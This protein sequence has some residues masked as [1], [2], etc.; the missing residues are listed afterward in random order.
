MKILVTGGSGRAGQ[1]IIPELLEH[2]HEVVNADRVPPA[3][4]NP[5]VRFIQIESTDYGDV[6]AASA[7][8]DAI[9]HMAAIP[10]PVRDPEHRV[11]QVNLLSDWNVLQ[12]AEVHGIPKVVMAS[13]VNAVGAVFSKAAI[14]PHYFPIDEAHPTRAEDAYSQSKW[15]GEQMAQGFC[16][17]RP[18]QIASMRFH[19][20]WD[21]ETQ[22]RYKANP[23]ADPTNRSAFHFWGWVDRRDAARACRLALE[24]DWEGQESFFINST[25][26]T[27][28]IPTEEAIEKAYPGAPIRKPLPGFASAIDISKAESMLGWQPEY[29]WRDA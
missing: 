4:S 13:S 7:G 26:T 1:Y 25:E 10:S 5:R 15:L 17:R 6:L 16:R 2:G 28:N 23:N 9:V 27:L 21:V 8:C 22:R 20:L 18:M 3:E 12:A 29:S 24:K 14:A 19:G 11:F